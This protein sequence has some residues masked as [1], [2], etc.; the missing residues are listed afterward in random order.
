MKVSVIVPVYNAE[1]TLI[2][3]LKRLVCQSLKEL[4]I[5]LVNDASTDASMDIMKTFEQKFPD[6]IMIV[7]CQE[8]RGAGGA[9]NIGMQYASGEYIGFVD[10]DDCVTVEMYEKLYN[11]AISGDYDF[12][13]CGYYDEARDYAIIHTSDELAGELDGKKRSELMVS[14]GY[15]VS[16][17]FKRSYLEDIGLTFRENCILED[18]E[19]LMQV[20]ATAKKIGNLKEILYQYKNTRAS[21]SKEMNYK[22]YYRGTTEAIEAIYHTMSQHQDYEEYKEAV[23]YAIVNLCVYSYNA[24]EIEAYENFKKKDSE[25]E[26]KI[27]HYLKDYVTIPLADNH[28]VQNKIDKEWIEKFTNLV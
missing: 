1:S 11:K 17:L 18:C 7:D 13:D 9:R 20:F 5:I 26:E 24:C 15:F 10:A 8:N 27:R 6:K 14:G 3:C 25:W 22:K 19:T 21:S 16:K 4:E 28:Y 2:E 23:E 12:V